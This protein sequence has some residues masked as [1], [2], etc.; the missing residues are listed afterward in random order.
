MQAA[1]P[2]VIVPDKKER[3]PTL[4]LLYCQLHCEGLLNCPQALHVASSCQPG[5]KKKDRNRHI[6][7]QDD[8]WRGLQN[9]NNFTQRH[10]FLG[11]VFVKLAGRLATPS[12]GS[13][14]PLGE[15]GVGLWAF[16]HEWVVMW[17]KRKNEDNTT[18]NAR[19][20]VR[21]TITQRNRITQFCK[22]GSL[23]NF[24]IEEHNRTRK[25]HYRVYQSTKRWRAEKN[26]FV[27]GWSNRIKVTCHTAV[28]RT[29]TMVWQKKMKNHLQY[30]KGGCFTKDL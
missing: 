17:V 22:N 28:D 11:L 13:H 19:F 3:L 9:T 16:E 6:C 7:R 27:Q 23:T 24:V 12:Q 18:V 26:V 20:M 4:E 15:F 1:C 2:A 30:F 21:Q 25:I 29:C 8:T 10:C 5:K 14:G